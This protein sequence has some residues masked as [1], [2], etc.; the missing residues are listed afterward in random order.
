M[1]S[2]QLSKLVML[3]MSELPS[4]ELQDDGDNHPVEAQNFGKN[5]DEDKRDK[6]TFVPC[7][8]SHSV[9]TY[10]ADGVSCS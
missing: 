9:I 6:N 7:E 3:R 4:P 2:L 10:N 1:V 5:Q 8:A